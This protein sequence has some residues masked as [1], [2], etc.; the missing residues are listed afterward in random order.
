MSQEWCPYCDQIKDEILNPMLRSGEYDDQVVLAEFKIDSEHS[1]RGFDG[2]EVGSNELA[3][4]YRVRVTP[5]LLFLDAQG[6][7]LTDRLRGINTPE[8]FGFYVDRAIL[9]ARDSAT[10][11]KSN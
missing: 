8:F 4:R 6:R 3:R 10:R 9:R 7:E 2:L 11:D 1:V 5:T